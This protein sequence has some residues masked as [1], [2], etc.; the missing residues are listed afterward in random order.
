MSQLTTR[1]YKGT[2]RR[3]NSPA[4]LK[5]FLLGALA[6]GL[7]AGLGTALVM[8]HMHRGAAVAC[9]AP[10]PAAQVQPTAAAR[11]PTAT[12][13]APGQAPKTVRR[14]AAPP[15]ARAGRPGAASSGEPAPAPP[16]YD[17]YQMLPNLKVIVP[18][19]TAPGARSVGSNG[20]TE[21][22]GDVL[23]VGAYNDPAQAQRVVTYLDS[24]GILAHIDTVHD[25]AAA[26]YRVRIGPIIERSELNRFRGVLKRIGMPGVLIPGATH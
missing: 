7:L 17:F 22:A 4:G 18:R 15:L 19:P 6:G 14:A 12:A 23:Q 13:A 1:D 20:R 16:Q 5:E 11:A 10:G 9:A 21:F 3:E 26:L 24:L 2:G 8:H 25:G